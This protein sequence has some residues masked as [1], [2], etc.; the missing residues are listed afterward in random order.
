[1]WGVPDMSIAADHLSSP[2]VIG[3]TWH[4]EPG[5][6]LFVLRA[7]GAVASCTYDRDQDVIGWA[8]QTFSGGAVESSATIPDQDA[9]RTMMLVRRTIDGNT[10]RYL[11]LLDSDTYTD[12]AIKGTSGSPTA[13]WTGLGHLEG[14]TV[15][16]R[17]D[18][19]PQPQKIVQS[20]QIVLALTASSVEIGLPLSMRVKM[21]PPEVSG[22]AGVVKGSEV[23]VHKVLVDVLD[24]IGLTVNGQQVAFRQLGD[25]VLDSQVR[26]FTGI[27][28][29]PGL[30]WETGG[31][32][33]EITHDDPLPCNVLAVVRKLTVNEG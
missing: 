28:E 25:G 29:V 1:M 5:T 4:E 31:G 30:D 6:L 13:T 15:S 11:E 24:T 9:D 3:L 22:G 23:R 17:A 21:L 12:C 18:G 7:D 33:V 26:P 19:I 14:Q 16:I 2:G 8:L 32:A 10:V 20:G 27:K